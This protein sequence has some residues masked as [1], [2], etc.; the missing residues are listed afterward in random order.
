MSKS[1]DPLNH[2]SIFKVNCSA[3]EVPEL[4]ATADG[5]SPIECG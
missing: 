2:V 3:A 4:Q 1:H 5:P